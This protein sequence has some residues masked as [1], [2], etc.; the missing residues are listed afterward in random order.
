MTPINQVYNVA[1]GDRIKG[2]TRDEFL[3]NR[4]YSGNA[5]VLMK[6][7]GKLRRIGPAKGGHCGMVGSA[8]V[9]QLQAM[10]Q[11]KGSVPFNTF[12]IE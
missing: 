8:I 10:S 3:D 2:T 1:V 9:R 11:T 5:F 4:Q 7:A 6:D 12:N